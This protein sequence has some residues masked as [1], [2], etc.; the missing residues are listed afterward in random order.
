MEEPS[1]ESSKPES[2]PE[3]KAKNSAENAYG[4]S[5][6]ESLYP[7]GGAPRE[8][9]AILGI[10]LILVLGAMVH[11]TSRAWVLET[12]SEA[13]GIARAVVTGSTP[14]GSYAYTGASNSSSVAPPSFGNLNEVVVVG[15][16]GI[17]TGNKEGADEGVG[18]NGGEQPKAL[19]L[20]RHKD[21]R[22]AGDAERSAA[23]WAI[24][25]ESGQTDV[26]HSGRILYHDGLTV[27]R[28]EQGEVSAVG[29]LTGPSVSTASGEAE[30]EP[31]RLYHYAAGAKPKLL[32]EGPARA[33]SLRY[34]ADEEFLAINTT[35]IEPSNAILK[36]DGAETFR[37][38]N[39][40][41]GRVAGWGQDPEAPIALVVAPRLGGWRFA[42]IVKRSLDGS[43]ATAITDYFDNREIRDDKLF[44]SPGGEN[45]FFR[46]RSFGDPLIPEHQIEVYSTE[47]LEQTASAP[48]KYAYWTRDGEGL[49]I[50]SGEEPWRRA[51]DPAGT[52][53][54]IDLR[55]GTIWQHDLPDLLPGPE[56]AGSGLLE[57]FARDGAL[58]DA[59]SPDGRFLVISAPPGGA[60]F[61]IV[62]LEEGA[63]TFEMDSHVLEV[64]KWS[65]NSSSVAMTLRRSNGADS[66][67]P[68]VSG[69]DEE[70]GEDGETRE[71]EAMV[72]EIATRK[73]VRF[74]IPPSTPLGWLAD[75]RI[76]WI[77]RPEFT[78]D[79]GEEAASLYIA[80]RDT[81]GVE[82]V[83][84]IESGK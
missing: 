41:E 71:I 24:D 74:D 34:S 81:M 2:P 47:N 56:G 49:I 38:G 44:F 17:F 25:L 40:G 67:T 82:K 51:E 39:A 83:T 5:T 33:K 45:F 11:P 36:T 52:L 59:L 37:W 3:G 66:E 30:G 29:Y 73:M 35:E 68:G 54:L 72:Y 23:L 78:F 69:E 64:L 42:Q 18:D 80:D 53:S 46:S 1:S 75:G 28:T 12:G 21:A 9:H 32:Y 60:G 27:R 15:S 31:R 79:R 48:G 13:Y 55:G 16:L 10:T 65:A 57:K 50:D 6:S 61:S 58:I 84:L 20:V 76:V 19:V 43:E 4:D 63:I 22:S 77:D 26:I 8:F 7:A 14:F 70:E 62:E